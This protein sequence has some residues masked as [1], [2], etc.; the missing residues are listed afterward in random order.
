MKSIF[1]KHFCLYIPVSHLNGPCQRFNNFI[2]G[3][4]G[5][6]EK[7]KLEIMTSCSQSALDHG[8]ESPEAA[9]VAFHGQVSKAAALS[10]LNPWRASD[11]QRLDFSLSYIILNLIPDV[12][13]HNNL[14]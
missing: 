13:R 1:Q 3:Y 9:P 4:L 7:P 2:W 11:L 10:P 5:L 14:I 8:G 12:R 6:S